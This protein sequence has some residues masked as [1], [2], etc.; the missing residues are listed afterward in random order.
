MGGGRL[1][2]SAA[3]AAAVLPA[4]PPPAPG[5]GYRYCLPQ[6]T[7]FGRRR[8]SCWPPAAGRR[9]IR[10]RPGGG[11][12]A[13][14]VA[15]ESLKG[16]HGAQ[17]RHTR[18]DRRPP[19]ARMGADSAEGRDHP[20]PPPLALSL[21]FLSYVCPSSRLLLPALAAP[22]FM[23]E[24][25][26]VMDSLIGDDGTMGSFFPPLTGEACGCETVWLAGGVRPPGV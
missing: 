1:I 3:A 22:S 19:A 8:F 14:R 18:L 7:D 2:S 12:V 23:G 17:L 4:G 20:P 9:P 13:G 6:A 25:A 21:V 16:F 5:P 11:R 15:R 24:C 26:W 10:T